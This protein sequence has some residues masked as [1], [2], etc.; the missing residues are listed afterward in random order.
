METEQEET[1]GASASELISGAE[2]EVQVPR[3]GEEEE[4]ATPHAAPH[5]AKKADKDA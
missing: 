2:G 3:V 4:Q 1:L 5:T